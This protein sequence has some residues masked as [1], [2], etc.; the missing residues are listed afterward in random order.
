MQECNYILV[1]SSWNLFVL[2]RKY[3]VRDKGAFV[4]FIMALETTIRQKNFRL[5]QLDVTISVSCMEK[6]HCLYVQQ[7]TGGCLYLQ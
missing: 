7:G 5:L 4:F 2:Q 6:N 1:K 3:S